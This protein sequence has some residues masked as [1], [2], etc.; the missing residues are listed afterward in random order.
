MAERD[1]DEKGREGAPADPP[2][3]EE[4]ASTPFDH[5][6]FLPALL[7]AFTVWFGYDGWLNP[8]TQSI[9][10]NRWGFVILLPMAAWFTLQAV[11]E[12]RGGK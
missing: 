9:L 12:R 7:I 2:D 4:R 3:S 10:F 11:R 6:Y 1:L 8:D 5:P